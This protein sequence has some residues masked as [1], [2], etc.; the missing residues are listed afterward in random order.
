MWL[1][2]DALIVVAAGNTGDTGTV[3]MNDEGEMKYVD[4][5]YTIGSPATLKNGVSVGATQRGDPAM[6]CVR[7][8]GEVTPCSFHNLFSASSRG[9]TFDER[10][11]PDVVFPGER[12]VSAASHGDAAT[13]RSCGRTV[14]KSGLHVI[15]GT[16]CYV[17]SYL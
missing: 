14:T 1:N 11:K 13:P 2:K 9:P 7:L 17:T 12:I 8:D 5:F 16:V 4:G 3:D 10:V 15:S 6:R